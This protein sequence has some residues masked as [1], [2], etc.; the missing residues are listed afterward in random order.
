MKRDNE[1]RWGWKIINRYFKI[2]LERN[3]LD[4]HTSKLLEL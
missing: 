3:T 4:K 1:H 2:E